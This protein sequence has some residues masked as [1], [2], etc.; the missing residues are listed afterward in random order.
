MSLLFIDGFDHYATADINKKWAST[1][2]SISS[3]GGRRGGG[4]FSTNG[5]GNS[6]PSNPFA[7]SST[8]IV[9]G[10]F[11]TANANNGYRVIFSLRETATEHLSLCI[12]LD[13]TISVFRGS[14]SGT[15]LGTS[16]TVVSQT[17]WNYVEI[18]ATIHS[19][20]GSIAVRINGTNEA[21]L[22]LTGINTRN[23]GTSGAVNVVSIGS[24]SG[25]WGFID[26]FYICDTNG[27][28]NND[29]LGDCRIDTIY[30]TSDG[31]YSQ[32]TPSTAGAHWSL[33]DETAPNTTD[34]VSSATVGQR[35]SFGFTDLSALAIDTVYG[36]QVNLAAMNSDAGARS[37]GTMARL[38]TTDK[39][40]AGKALSAAQTYVSEVYETDPNNAAWTLANFNLTEF[41]AKVTA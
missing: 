39:D 41:G 6:V 23:G 2:G 26:D 12:N 4:A 21:S 30:P 33:V 16:T 28:R 8:I 5:Y 10:A 18:K 32:F 22:S 17:N 11:K 20:T 14:Q 9:G 19:T 36:V 7:S 38:G 3:T 34:Y 25:F 27:T 35:D 15:L 1:S 31:N 40:G 37:A 29:F 13:G 24:G